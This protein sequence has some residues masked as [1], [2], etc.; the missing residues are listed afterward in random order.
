MKSKKDV[1]VPKSFA[2]ALEILQ[3]YQTLSKE[4]R[5]F[6]LSKQVLK[7]GT[8]IGANIREAKGAISKADFSA[9][10]SISYKES[11]ETQYWLELLFEG[12][13]LAENL[14]KKMF[15]NCEELSKILY[16]AIKTSRG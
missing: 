8:S 6:I 5:E 12:G 14:Y 2:F 7:S 3:L 1:L 11:L 15:A 10:L 9:K 4:K 13:Y 16:S